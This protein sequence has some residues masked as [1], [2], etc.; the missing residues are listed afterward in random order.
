MFRLWESSPSGAFVKKRNL[1]G[2][3]PCA[4]ARNRRYERVPL[5]TVPA[6]GPRENRTWS[7]HPGVAAWRSLPAGRL[8]GTVWTGECDL[9]VRGAESCLF[10]VAGG[11]FRDFRQIAHEVEEDIT[12]VNKITALQTVLCLS[13]SFRINE[14]PIC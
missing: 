3:D 10:R 2:A 4:V 9:G 12:G 7:V 5:E 6:P 14:S 8:V 1:C 11:A 13:L